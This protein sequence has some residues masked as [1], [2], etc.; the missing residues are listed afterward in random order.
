MAGLG[1]CLED[2]SK[3]TR[4]PVLV[5]MA[6]PK[7]EQG[8]LET[9]FVRNCKNVYGIK[10][11]GTAGGCTSGTWEE[12]NGQAVSATA[13]FRKYN[14]L[15]ES[16]Q[17]FADLVSTSSRYAPAMANKDDPAEFVRKLR[18]GGY[19]TDSAWPDK[20][21]SIMDYIKSKISV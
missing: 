13:T 18:E 7:N 3:A 12:E 9:D 15:C 21:I 8:W 14:T 16:V 1:Q 17:D 19:A 6:I 2:T 5:M 4:V 10:G 20:I 11:T